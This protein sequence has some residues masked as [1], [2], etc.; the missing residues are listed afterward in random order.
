MKANETE[1]DE[2][3]R[4]F[5][6]IQKAC[7]MLNKMKSRRERKNI[8][9]DAEHSETIKTE[10]DDTNAQYDDDEAQY[11]DVNT[12]NDD[13]DIQAD[14]KYT[15]TDDDD[16]DHEEDIENS[17]AE[18]LNAEVEIKKG[19]NAGDTIKNWSTVTA[20]ESCN[21]DECGEL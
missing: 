11:S 5:I 14:D 21:M 9:S 1:K 4:K 18:N 8:W 20:T 12:D 13:V 17:Q 2:A 7:L 19:D 6:D 3:E 10:T 16:P 15:H